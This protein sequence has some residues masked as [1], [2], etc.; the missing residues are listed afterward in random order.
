MVREERV[1]TSMVPKVNY[2]S[3]SQD[4]KDIGQASQRGGEGPRKNTA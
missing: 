3:G 2:Q 4:V 1:K